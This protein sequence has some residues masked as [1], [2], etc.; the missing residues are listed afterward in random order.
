[1]GTREDEPMTIEPAAYPTDPA[2]FHSKKKH[3]ISDSP[4]KEKKE[5]ANA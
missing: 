1:M 4:D 3:R 5:R 2:S